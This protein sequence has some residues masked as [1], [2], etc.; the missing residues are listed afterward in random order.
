MVMKK[1]VFL[2]HA[3]S[4]WTEFSGS[5][6]FISDH[7]RPLS[8][9]GV[10][11]CT[12]LSKY[13]SENKVEFDLIEYSTAVR[14]VKTYELV[15][16]S[17]PKTLSRGNPCLYTFDYKKLMEVISS[18]CDSIKALLIVGHNPA[19][20]ELIIKLTSSYHK[21]PFSVSIRRKFPTAACAFLDLDIMSWIEI[22]ENCGQITN[23]FTPKDLSFA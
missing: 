10:K 13:F 6:S 20:Q 9:R 14:A 3:K 19:I 21:N 7:D 17:L 4:D 1:L 18:V 15:K 8:K 5:H 11:A 16:S 22:D 2:R 12:V 23:F